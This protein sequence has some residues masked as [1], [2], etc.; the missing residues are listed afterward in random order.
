[1]TTMKKFTNITATAQGLVSYDSNGK[2]QMER[3]A[4]KFQSKSDYKPAH[5]AKT[6]SDLEKIHLNMVQRQMFRRLMY[7]LKEYAPEQIASLSPSALSKIVE[8]YKKAK[9]ALHII[10][11]KKYY[12]AETKLMN[13][14]F[15]SFNIGSKDHD[16]FL[17]LPK[18]VTLRSLGIST[19]EV[20]DEFIKRK[21]LPK[22]FYKITIQNVNL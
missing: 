21:L 4:H 22:H 10:K 14:I 11:A 17:E 18:S 9:R 19:K 3:Y 8:D 1:M 15:P 5:I 20:I 2:V 16:W 6:S 7:G 12:E 13:A